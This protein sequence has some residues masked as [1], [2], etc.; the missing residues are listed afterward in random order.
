MGNLSADKNQTVKI[1]YIVDTA[2]GAT[3]AFEQLR[4]LRNKYGFDVT[5]FVT[6][7]QGS[8]VDKLRC[9]GIPCYV[10]SF[11]SASLTSICT[12]PFKVLGLARLF[13]R[14]R[15]DV[16]QT[17]LFRSMVIG[18]LAAWLADVPVRLAMVAGPYHLEAHTLRWID[19]HTCWMDTAV[20][21]S[22]EYTRRL[23]RRM[24]VADV[25][26]ELIY[27]GADESRFNP[28]QLPPARIREE[29]GWPA[30]TPLI[31][32]V[33]YFYPPWHSSGLTPPAIK[34]RGIKGHEYLIKAAPHILAEFPTAKLLLI[35]SALN[36]D[37]QR[38]MNELKEVVHRLGLQ[39]SI[40]F[41]GFRSDINSVLRALDVSVQP[42]LNEN[43]GGTIES[44][45]MERPL[46]A[47]RVGGMVDSVRDGE[48]GVLVEPANSD[49]LA[50]GILQLLRDPERAHRLARAGRNLML[51]R[52]TLSRTLRDLSELY[53]RLLERDGDARRKYRLWVSCYRL[54]AL[55]PVSALLALRMILELFTLRLW[56]AIRRTQ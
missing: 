10:W 53:H 33:A 36:E 39:E 13:R 20:I 5:A 31:G 17:H 38:Y 3:W 22:C 7:H 24:G 40:I 8:L 37:G 43:L 15:F 34:G 25:H 23:Y 30:D 16:V 49:E 54:V 1:C 4:D 35:G 29:Y 11:G 42:S 56:D 19:R 55:A 18:R 41:T 27:Y 14:E 6:N 32:M 47:T 9:E 51:E 50:R 28:E 12:L 2:V 48:T 44:L 52:F 46:V 26:L 21:A 45:L